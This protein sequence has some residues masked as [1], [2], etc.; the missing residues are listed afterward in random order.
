MRA[1][2]CILL[3]GADFK[4][5]Q[6]ISADEKIRLFNGNVAPFYLQSLT[7]DENIG[8]FPMRL[9][10]DAAKCLAGNVHA[11]GSLLLV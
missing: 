1:C 4:F 11:E 8:Y 6:A 5:P 2:S 10:N 3:R 7:V 9:G